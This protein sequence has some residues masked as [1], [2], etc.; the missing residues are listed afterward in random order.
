MTESSP[1]AVCECQADQSPA[2]QSVYEAARREAEIYK[3]LESEKR[4]HDV[5]EKAIEDWY[6]RFWN[7]YCRSRRVEH[8]AGEQQWVEFAV[9]EFGCMYA[10]LTAGDRV[11]ED[12]IDRFERGWENLDFAEW[13]HDEQKSRG[14]IEEIIYL[15]EMININIARL[16]RRQHPE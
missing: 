9:H 15:L 13:V 11:L 3:W 12:L 6:R 14:Q 16:D 4:G 8:L 5:G 7:K 2:A 10:M 1:T